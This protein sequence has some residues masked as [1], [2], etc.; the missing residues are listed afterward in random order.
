[1][2]YILCA[3]PLVG[4]FGT[5]RLAVK[6]FDVMSGDLAGYLNAITELT[7]LLLCVLAE[8]TGG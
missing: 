1:M 3:L 5:R 6:Q 8:R 7:E 4:F 2:C